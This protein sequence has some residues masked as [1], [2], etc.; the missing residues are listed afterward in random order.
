LF[1]YQENTRFLGRINQN[2]SRLFV[3]RKLNSLLDNGDRSVIV[4]KILS[5]NALRKIKKRDGQLKRL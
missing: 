4:L 1:Y 5:L 2:F 3:K